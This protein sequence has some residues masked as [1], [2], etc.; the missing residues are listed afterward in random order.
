MQLKNQL[1]KNSGS[2]RGHN[3]LSLGASKQSRTGDGVALSTMFNQD[4][5][6]QKDEGQIPLLTSPNNSVV[7]EKVSMHICLFAS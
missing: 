7:P 5:D 2:F 3:Q 6:T 1:Q 4:K